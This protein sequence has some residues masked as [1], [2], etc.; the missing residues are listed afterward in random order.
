MATPM[1]TTHGI[2]NM[3]MLKSQILTMFA[4]RSGNTEDGIFMAIWAIILITCI[5]AFFRHIPALLVRLETLAREYLRSRMNKF[6]IVS[7]ITPVGI[8]MP[9]I[10]SVLLHRNYKENDSDKY[11][12]ESKEAIL[13][14]EL[15]DAV[16]EFICSQD[17]SRHL[18]YTNKY[19]M[20]NSDPIQMTK[21][22]IAKMEHCDIDGKTNSVNS[23]TIK[24]SSTTLKISQIKEQLNR[25]L[26]LCTFKTPI[27]YD[28]LK[29]K[30]SIEA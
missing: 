1:G 8:I 21:D 12:K 14:Y 15:V 18:R 25:I 6:P 16:I 28:V 22:I 27:L 9:E 3:D 10:A 30:F 5:D 20:N 26:H 23:I 7:S 29:Q 4:L 24:I 19:Y 17:S 2:G 13:D 11:T